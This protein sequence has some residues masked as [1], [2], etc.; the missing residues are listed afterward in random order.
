LRR[1][2]G[3]VCRAAVA[4]GLALVAATSVAAED[5]YLKGA[6]L[7]YAVPAPPAPGS[8]LARMDLAM[9]RAVQATP[10][11][12]AW[13]EADGDARAY[14]APVVIS[15]FE[16]AWGGPLSSADRPILVHVLTRVI[17][18]MG[19]YAADAKKTSPRDRPYV[20]HADIV[21]CNT[22]Y[23][24]DNESYPSGHAMNGYVVA[25][26]LADLRP[27]RETTLLARGVR[28]GDNRVVCGVHHPIDVQQGRLLGIAY[29]E[30]VRQNPEFRAEFDCARDE[31]L[32]LADGAHAMPPACARLATP[33][34]APGPKP[35]SG[36]KDK[37]PELL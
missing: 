5:G 20:G 22:R 33:P 31:D 17:Q 28:Y 11:S 6:P 19:G 24:K 16:D 32:R 12:A 30:A 21:A 1:V 15:R 10:S 13:Q 23:L 36:A 8:E 27:A 4:A 26:L 34:A 2:L 18:D 25:A 3:L 37:T 29:L 9:V 14:L 7:A 35:P